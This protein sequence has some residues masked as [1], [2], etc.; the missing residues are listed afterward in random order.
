MPSR[1]RR[2]LC[3]AQ[4]KRSFRLNRT[5]LVKRDTVPDLGCCAPRSANNHERILLG[6]ALAPREPAKIRLVIEISSSS[7][8]PLAIPLVTQIEQLHR[9]PTPR[10]PR[11]LTQPTGGL[12]TSGPPISCR[13]MWRLLYKFGLAI[14]L[15]FPDS[16][17]P[18]MT[19]QFTGNEPYIAHQPDLEPKQETSP[20]SPTISRLCDSDITRLWRLGPRLGRNAA[21]AAGLSASRLKASER[22]TLG[23]RAPDRSF[24]AKACPAAASY[25]VAMVRLRTPSRSG[26]MAARRSAST[27]CTWH[28][29]P[30]RRKSS[31]SSSTSLRRP[32]T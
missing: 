15:D 13:K 20:T 19:E 7:P 16:M 21:P 32:L 4:A 9:R 18:L 6:L 25:L 22:V 1:C 17:R 5:H 14:P 2:E 23:R 12:T 30:R 26:A 10:W 28:P 11:T 24:F 3:L 27:T 8:S 31:A 29:C